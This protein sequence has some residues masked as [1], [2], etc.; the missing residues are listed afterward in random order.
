MLGDRRRRRQVGPGD[1]AAPRSATAFSGF[2][3]CARAASRT[4]N[5][6]PVHLAIVTEGGLCPSRSKRFSIRRMIRFLTGVF[7]AVGAV[8]LGCGGSSGPTRG[9]QCEEVM[10]AYCNRAADP[11]QIIPT[12]QAVS[13]C[14][15]S[16]VPA[17]CDGDCG[18]SVISTEAQIDAC[19]A[20]IEAASCAS[21]D[22]YTGGSVPSSCLGVVES[23]LVIGGGASGLK[24]LDTDVASHVG[25]LISR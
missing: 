20:D 23:D 21:L 1:G 2:H 17:C 7:L 11:C 3:P 22:V 5:T 10:Q 4:R 12:G 18:A 6:L 13:N 14:I 25:Q 19:I 8:T 16:G 24:S 9:M 15:N